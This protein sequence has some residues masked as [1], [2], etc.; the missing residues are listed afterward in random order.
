MFGKTGPWH[1]ELHTT[2]AEQQ[3]DGLLTADGAMRLGTEVRNSPRDCFQTNSGRVALK[4][5]FLRRDTL[6]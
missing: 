6:Q 2:S 5:I 3:R 4:D 1:L